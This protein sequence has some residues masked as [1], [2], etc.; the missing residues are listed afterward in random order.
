[1][2]N[3]EQKEHWNSDEASHWVAHQLRYDTMLAPF[4]DRLLAAAGISGPDRVLD[5]G[6]GCGATTLESGRRAVTGSATGLD[7]STSMLDVGR[8]RA[9]EER[10]TNVSF[11]AGDAQTYPFP[12][13]GF[14]VAISRFGLMFFDDPKAAFSNL[15]GAL[16]I[17]SRLA[18]VCWQD[19]VSNPFIAVPGLAIAQHVE[20]PDMGPPGAPGMFALADP[21]RIRSLLADAGLVDVVIEPLAEEI[22]LGGG[23]TLAEAVEFLREGSMGRAVLAGVDAA[24]QDRAVIAVRDALAPYVT[25]EGVRIGTAAWLVTARRP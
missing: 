14:D 16:V 21:M 20:L 7:L 10:L 19:L 13:G 23:G 15:A 5:V 2:A 17:G 6:C 3:E 24:T 8:R 1:M 11:V 4:C 25:D 9:A 12:D 18:F 22:L